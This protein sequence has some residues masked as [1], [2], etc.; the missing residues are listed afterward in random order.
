MKTS[1]PRIDRAVGALLN[2]SVDDCRSSMPHYDDVDLL[3]KVRAV[4]LEMGHKTRATIIA[5]RIKQ[6]ETK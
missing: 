6:L 1:I 2:T 3:R 5:R 4:A